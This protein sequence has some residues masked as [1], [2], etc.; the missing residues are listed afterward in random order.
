MANQ[1]NVLRAL[2]NARILLDSLLY[3]DRLDNHFIVEPDKFDFN[4]MG[5]Y[6]IAAA[7]GMR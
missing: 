6:D 1:R 4:A 2:E 5:C 3:P 7:L